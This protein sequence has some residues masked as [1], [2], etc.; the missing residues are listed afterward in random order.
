MNCLMALVVSSLSLGG[1]AGVIKRSMRSKGLLF[2]ICAL[3]HICSYFVLFFVFTVGVT[4]KKVPNGSLPHEPFSLLNSFHF[5][6]VESDFAEDVVVLIAD[7]ADGLHA[8]NACHIAD[9]LFAI[10]L[11]RIAP[12]QPFG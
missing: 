8:F 10:F 6:C 9:R 1:L 11:D 7:F 5:D 3:Y 2:A 4:T 12:G